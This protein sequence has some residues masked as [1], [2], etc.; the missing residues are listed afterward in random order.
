[1]LDISASLSPRQLKTEWD[2]ASQEGFTHL[3]VAKKEHYLP[4]HTSV[5]DYGGE[6]AFGAMKSETQDIDDFLAQQIGDLIRTGKSFVK[7]YDLSEANPFL[8]PS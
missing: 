1:M 6:I 3:I 2:K 8:Q 4:A 5:L 7:I